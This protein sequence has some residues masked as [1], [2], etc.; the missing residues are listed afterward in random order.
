MEK[1]DYDYAKINT[2]DHHHVVDNVGI[3]DNIVVLLC[4]GQL[5]RGIVYEL[6]RV[7]WVCDSLFCSMSATYDGAEL[8]RQW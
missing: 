3:V 6:E 5:R 1:N 8:L 7:L 2:R 4:A